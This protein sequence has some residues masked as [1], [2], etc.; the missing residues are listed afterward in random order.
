MFVSHSLIW[1]IYLQIFD[2]NYPFNVI[3]IEMSKYSTPNIWDPMGKSVLQKKINNNNANLGR[4][5]V[6]FKTCHKRQVCE[7]DNT[8][9]GALLIYLG[10]ND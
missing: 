3:L 4:C 1:Y 10:G 9:K 5:M 7:S 8:L 6:T 2:E